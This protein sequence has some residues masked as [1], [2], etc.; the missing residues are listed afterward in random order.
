M[1]GIRWTAVALTIVALIL[2]A[3]AALQLGI[4]VPFDVLA[5]VV[6][7]AALAAWGVSL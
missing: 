3:L 5:G 7:I 1:K 4:D 6:W 2:T